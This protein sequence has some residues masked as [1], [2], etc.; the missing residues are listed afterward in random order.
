MS[1]VIDKGE[2]SDGYH[3][4]NELYEHRNLL[5]ILCAKMISELGPISRDAIWKSRFHYDGSDYPGWFIL[6]IGMKQGEQITYH[7]P[8]REWEHCSFAKTLQRA[9]K[10]DGHTS[11]DILSRLR[12][13]ING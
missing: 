4:F 9:P 3:T 12:A 5:F 1:E 13:E 2:I 10:W 6:G 7:L 11:Q 8:D